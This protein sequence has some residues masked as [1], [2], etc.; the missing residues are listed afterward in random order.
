VSSGEV[1]VHRMWKHIERLGH[2]DAQKG[3]RDRGDRASSK[4]IHDLNTLL[5]HACPVPSRTVEFRAL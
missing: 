5:W 3:Q 1:V 4:F 2:Y